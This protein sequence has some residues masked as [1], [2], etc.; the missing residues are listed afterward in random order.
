MK[1][2]NV[3]RFKANQQYLAIIFGVSQSFISR[4][5]AGMRS[6]K[7]NRIEKYIDNMITTN[8]ITVNEN[9]S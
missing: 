2:I 5:L 6:S 1:K 7:N 8:E 4:I 3:I 9:I